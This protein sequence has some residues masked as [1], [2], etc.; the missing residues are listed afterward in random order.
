MHTNV[1]RAC[2]YMRILNLKPDLKLNLSSQSYYDLWHCTHSL[3]MT[4][5]TNLCDLWP[6]TFLG[7]HTRSNKLIYKYYES[8]VRCGLWPHFFTKCFLSCKISPVWLT[9]V[10]RTY[11]GILNLKSHF[12][13]DLSLILYKVTH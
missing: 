6:L 3:T 1:L 7:G 13:F 8:E 2:R 4:F 11:Y 10:L 12:T 5:D 9:N